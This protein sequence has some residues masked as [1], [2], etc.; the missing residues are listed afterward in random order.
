VLPIPDIYVSHKD[1]CREIY[2]TKLSP[3]DH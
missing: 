3:F 2:T 1:I